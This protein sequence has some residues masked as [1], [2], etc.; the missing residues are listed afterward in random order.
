[1]HDTKSTQ[2]KRVVP[3]GQPQT[4]DKHWNQQ[5]GGESEAAP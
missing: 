2:M 1:M 5:T 3:T 4:T